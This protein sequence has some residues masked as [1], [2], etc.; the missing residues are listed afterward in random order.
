MM[1]NNI[2]KF[3]SILKLEKPVEEL[4]IRD[5]ITAYRKLVKNV[6]PDTSGYASKED[7]QKLGEAY[8]SI[9]KIAVNRAKA[10]ENSVIKRKEEEKD[11]EE[12]TEEKFVKENFH[13]FNFPTEK[14]GSFVIKVEN[15]LADMWD[16][17][18]INIYGEP[19]V[20][21]TKTGT[22]T[23]RLWR[24]VYQGC[25]LT[26]HFYK[27][28]KTTKISKF[29]VQGGNHMK[30]Y[31]FVFTE[32]PLIYKKVCESKPLKIRNESQQ[33]D[34]ST[35]TCDKCKFK[36]TSMIQMKKHLKAI[37]NTNRS[38]SKKRVAHFTP[39]S[40]PSKISKNVEYSRSNY[41]L[42]AEG[43][44]DESLLMLDNTF[45][46]IQ[47]TLEEETI[48]DEKKEMIV[49]QVEQQVIY[50][51]S[52]C[53]F[54]T[55]S[56]NILI[57]HEEIHMQTQ[58]SCVF[59]DK[60][61]TVIKEHNDHCKSLPANQSSKNA[62]IHSKEIEDTD[63]TKQKQSII[64]CDTCAEGFEDMKEFNQHMEKDHREH[65]Q[66]ECEVCTDK[67][68]NE[69]ELQKHIKNQHSKSKEHSKNTEIIQCPHCEFKSADL[70]T[71]DS[72]IENKHVELAFL[73]HISN[74]QTILYK[75][76]EAFKKELITP[77]NKIIEGHNVMKQ[78]LV[79]LRQKN[80]DSEEKIEKLENTIEDLKK[81]L[82]DKTKTTIPRIREPRVAQLKMKPVE[83]MG[84][85]KKT[86]YLEKPKVL[87]I[88]DSIAH[89][90]NMGKV[91]KDTN[92]RVKTVKAYSAVEDLKS[93]YPSKN[94]TDVTPAALKDTREEDKYTELVLA[95][96]SVDITN[97]NTGNLNGDDNIEVFEQ[98][99]IISCQNMLSVAQNAVIDNP[100]LRKVVL[101][102]HAPRQDPKEVDPIR[103]K[104]RLAK[105][106][107]STL[108]Q[109]VQN[110]GFAD[111][112]VMG[113]HSLD[114]TN[115]NT[116]Y[117]DDF[118][119]RYDGVHMHGSH[120]KDIFT[121]SV[122]RIIR[123]V[124]PVTT[125]TTRPTQHRP[126]YSHVTCPQAQY[127]KRRQ[128]RAELSQHYSVPVNNRFTVLGN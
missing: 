107:N 120:G 123:S 53:D 32:L 29:L 113:R 105:L 31:C 55:E 15:D 102:E 37:H 2:E 127:Q 122:E 57:N 69:S 84:I 19:K 1:V 68:Q 121:R 82:D 9:L 90:V 39:A 10:S 63:V 86:K 62:I 36:T 87:Y 75:N 41:F 7:F 44:A 88:G 67:F 20:N 118:T 80:I 22:E 50:S 73:G 128:A 5:V 48:I 112:I 119:G 42:N 65:T 3:L 104:P 117:R 78:D 95:A 100:Q 8:E 106:A 21:R 59:E 61:E 126:L 23:S 11:E 4:S 85:K 40:K 46:G 24:I 109:L 92:S 116:V 33:N 93:R 52:K 71:I 77:L 45:G 14:E 72:H 16:E 125:T 101:M 96:P 94:F 108:A 111:K 76:F 54:D 115:A 97:I 30:K 124:L 6:H 18:F 91:E 25:E 81:L 49:N 26:I 64:I 56:E 51:C 103:L 27:K 12:E 98:K 83:A 89:N 110:S 28:P 99:V 47:T 66:F 114:I 60:E 58:C 35:A 43:I 79:A 74:N 13:N 34:L 17:C 38:K 70:V